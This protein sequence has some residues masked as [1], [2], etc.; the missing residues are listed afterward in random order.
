VSR[1]IGY[2]FLPATLGADAAL[3]FDVFDERVPATVAPDVVV[4]PAGDRMRG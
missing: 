4:D 3:E 2:V 1:T